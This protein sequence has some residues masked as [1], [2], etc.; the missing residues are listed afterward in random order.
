MD[1][2]IIDLKIK[3]QHLEQENEVLKKQKE[4][5]P[6]VKKVWDFEWACYYCKDIKMSKTELESI[7]RDYKFNKNHCTHC[8]RKNIKLELIHRQITE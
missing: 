3:I 4:F 7:H 5:K 6:K 1:N 2:I 8:L